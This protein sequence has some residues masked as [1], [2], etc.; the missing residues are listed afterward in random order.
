MGFPF[1]GDRLVV[2]LAG[3]LVFWRASVLPSQPPSGAAASQTPEPSSGRA[4]NGSYAIEAQARRPAASSQRLFGW[5]AYQSIVSRAAGE[6][7]EAHGV[8]EQIGTQANAP[9][10]H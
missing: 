3:A 4:I 6:M 1:A 8:F 5:G 2:S 9:R 10:H 7:L